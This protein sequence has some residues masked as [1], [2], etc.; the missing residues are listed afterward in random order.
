MNKVHL[1][2]SLLF[3]SLF[4]VQCKQDDDAVL[5]LPDYA[6]AGGNTTIF[7]VTTGAFT[8]PAPNLS[9]ENLDKHLEGDVAFEQIFVTPPSELNPGL[10]PLFNNNSCVSCHVKNG[11]SQP[12]FDGDEL[13]GFL[14][15]LSV[16]G[17]DPIHGAKPV[18]HFGTQ[19]QNKSIFNV[20]KEASYTTTFEEKN[21]SLNEGSTVTLQRP[22]FHLENGHVDIPN[23][24]QISPRVAPAV[25]GLGLLESISVSDLQNLE[26]EFDS[27]GDGISGKLNMVWNI[28]QQ[29]STI[30]RFGWKAENPSSLQQTADAYH[31]D[32]GITTNLFP[33]EN[34]IEQDNCNGDDGVVDI[35][36]EVLEATSFYFQT[37]AV[38]APRN[39]DSEQFISGLSLF[40]EIGCSACHVSSFVTS[41]VVMKEL[42]NQK[43]F[44]YTDLL[45]HDMGEDLTDNRPSFL[46]EGNEWRTPPLWGIGLTEL[47]NGHTRFLHDGRARN[48]EEAI[49][50][51][52]GEAL[53]AQ[54][55]YV[56]LSSEERT[57]LLFFLNSL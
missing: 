53:D 50:W 44:P 13:S 55:S 27:D 37:L 30:G 24:V 8:F 2:I 19:L 46:A 10:G 36:D 5:D 35:T 1:Y 23:N 54:K 3:C 7:N 15:R 29:S 25:F 26:D 49:L 45:L 40:D 56:Q 42:S 57:D 18:P 33:D 31:Q 38:P 47:V 32:M 21:I 17:N 20:V 43:I 22:V 48:I 41:D 28:N 16:P 4:F 34:C 11:R 39:Y 51:H 14:L 52:G 9:Q 12:A 6:Y